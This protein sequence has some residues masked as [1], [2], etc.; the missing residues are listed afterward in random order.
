MKEGKPIW[1]PHKI[2]R[3]DREKI[4]KQKGCV[5]WFTG[6]S[7]SGKST[8]AN[9]VEY[10]LNKMG[11]HTYLL[12]GDNIR[13]GLNKDLGFSIE[14]RRENIRR[15]AEVAKLFLDAGIITIVSVISPFEKDRKLAKE[16]I[17][18]DFIEVFIDTPLKECI[19]RDPKGLYKKALEGRVKNFVGVDIEYEIPKNPDIHIKTNFIQIQDTANLVVDYLS[20]K[21]YIQKS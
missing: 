16:I 3:E 13:Y 14:D 15:I 20:R 2:T 8:I 9:E 5:L 7:G 21:K 4:K 11:F 19:K 17:G 10:K 1:Q 18:K 6:L 12:D